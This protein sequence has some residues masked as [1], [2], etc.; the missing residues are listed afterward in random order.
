[1]MTR[2]RCQRVSPCHL[3]RDTGKRLNGG[4]SGVSGVNFISDT[5]GAETR[6]CGGARRVT[7]HPLR[8]RVAFDTPP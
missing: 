5:G 4:G 2:V 8:G 3:T 1:M 6:V 7:C